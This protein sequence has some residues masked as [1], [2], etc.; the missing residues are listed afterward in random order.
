MLIGP[1]LSIADFDACDDAG[2]PDDVSG[3]GSRSSAELETMADKIEMQT[4]LERMVESLEAQK[5]A[6]DTVLAPLKE[7]LDR[8][9]RQPKLADVS[10]EA[11]RLVGG[12]RSESNQ[13]ERVAAFLLKENNQPKT[14]R[15]L[16]EGSRVNHNSVA[17]ML[18]TTHRGNFVV[19]RQKGFKNRRVWKLTEQ[20]LNAARQQSG[21]I[22]QHRAELVRHGA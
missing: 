8:L 21:P 2:S 22:P 16:A 11:R 9:K 17:T 1:Q 5:Q 18:Y 12:R 7:A 10:E 14:A 3:S 13:Y 20:A 6:L 4:E 19:E 15:E